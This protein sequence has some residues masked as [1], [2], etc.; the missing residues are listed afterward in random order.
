LT[1]VI[2]GKDYTLTNEEW[3][4]PS[5]D[6]S[7]AQGGSQTLNFDMGPLGPQ[8]M[9]EVDLDHLPRESEAVALDSERKKHSHDA[10]QH[11][12]A[13]TIMHMDIKKS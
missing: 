1:L 7:M 6:I 5:Q 13:S 2:N 4:F 3:M 11:A 8:L 9:A 10:K 12:C